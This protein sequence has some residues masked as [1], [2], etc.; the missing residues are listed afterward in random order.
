MNA[1]IIV[2]FGIAWLIFGYLWYGNIIK[3]KVIHSNDDNITP[4]REIN[5]GKDYVPTKPAILFGH[6]FS[7]IAG[8]G[9]I[10]GPIIGYFLFGW[11]PALLWIILGSVFMGAVHDYTSLIASL[12]NKG[13]SITEVAELAVSKR[14][15]KIFA[16]FVWVTLTLVQAVFADLTAK[17]L[18]DKPE[19]VVPT[20][21]IML[22]AM[23]FGILVF[24]KGLKL[25]LGT[26]LGL[27][28]LFGLIILGDYAPIVASYQFWLI[29]TIIYSLIAAT[30]PVWILLQPR[31]YLS[32]YLL[33]FGLLIG[34]V[35]ILVLHPTMTGPMY[36]SFD[37]KNGPLFPILFITVSCG[38][39]SGF[40]SLVA[41]GTSSKQLIKESD[42][43]FVA[44]GSMLTEALLAL[45]VIVMI[46]SVLPWGSAANGSSAFVFQDLF[47][48][49]ANIVFGTALGVT[50]KSIGIPLAFGISFGVL[51]LNAFILTTLDTSARLNRYIITE[52]LGAK[53]GGIFKNKYFAAGASLIFAYL[54]CLGG[55]YKLLWPVF[56]ASNQLIASLSL[57]V[58]SVYFLGFK[59]PKWY[60]LIPAII[61]LIVTETALVYSS[62]ANFIP[63]EKWY[64]VVISLIL[65]ILGL[66][67]AW[68]VTKKLIKIQKEKKTLTVTT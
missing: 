3:K 10:V 55:G 18:A 31:D 2:I 68:E 48:K 44:F 37:S 34:V 5:D 24:R 12:R 62:V 16:V 36:I 1:A 41:S 7:S 45:L 63:K 39:I 43:K 11:L 57:F 20:I 53:Y 28:T 46:A 60:T 25:T 13:V 65:F 49:S 61:M 4:S 52:T 26:V 30:L 58:A 8:A 19:I 66:V 56:G 32:M 15:S 51:M 29:F 33:I 59:A 35:G 42:G 40:H 64:L 27:L 38:A 17:T 14:A 9:P 23:V 47:K 54:L 21:G 6:H 50:V 67:V 22:I